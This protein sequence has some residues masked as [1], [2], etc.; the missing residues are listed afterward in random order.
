MA[1]TAF[2][3]EAFR[4]WKP[5]RPK[6]IPRLRP[7]HAHAHDHKAPVPVRSSPALPCALHAPAPPHSLDSQPNNQQHPL[8][9]RPPAEVCVHAN[10]QPD[11]R[12][13]A[14]PELSE[15]PVSASSSSNE[16]SVSEIDESPAVSAIRRATSPQAQTRCGSPASDLNR[17]GNAVTTDI[18][19]GSRC[20]IQGAAG[21]RSPSENL[22]SSA[23][24]SS[25]LQEPAVVPIDPVILREEF[26]FE[27]NQPHQDIQDSDAPWSSQ[28][29]LSCPYPEPPIVLHSIFDNDRLP[30]GLI[31]ENTQTTHRHYGE[32]SRQAHPGNNAESD[33]SSPRGPRQ[34][35]CYSDVNRTEKRK[36]PLTG[37]EERK[38][39]RNKQQ[40]LEE[41]TPSPAENSCAS[42]RFKFLSLPTNAR[43]E[44]LS[45]L[46][47]GAL[48]RCTFEPEIVASITPAKSKVATRVRKQVRWAMPP[49]AA[50]SLNNSGN[51]EKPR[52]G[53]PWSLEEEDLLLELRNT[54]GLPWSDVTKLFSDQYPGRSQGSIQVY[55]STKL[56]KR[57]S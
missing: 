11:I 55:W 28:Q 8:P 27:S 51:L 1:V 43:L 3:V 22:A 24:Q 49:R 13:S 48:P 34:P 25:G 46:F 42:L 50:D 53:M 26:A 31:D 2:P 57:R 54:R 35:H 5:P 9:A 12:Q 21:C 29:E 14:C 44:F 15:E 7:P 32:C 52:K 4:P 23:Q 18:S 37:S 38:R 41:T 36:R 16:M 47:E 17:L 10:L 39:R 19:I 6:R 20:S 45:W 30:S 33:G 40:R 56:K